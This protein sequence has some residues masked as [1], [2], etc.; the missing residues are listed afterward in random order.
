M[1]KTRRRQE[2]ASDQQTESEESCYARTHQYRH[3]ILDD[4]HREQIRVK[5][6]PGSANIFPTENKTETCII[7]SVLRRV[8]GLGI[9]VIS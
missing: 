9:G 7:C 6:M 5:T 2:S 4:V 1:L 3:I 8:R